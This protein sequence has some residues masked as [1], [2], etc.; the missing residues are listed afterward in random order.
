MLQ[1]FQFGLVLSHAN[2]NKN[3]L[4]NTLFEHKYFKINII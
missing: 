2:M 3:T 1:I 4:K